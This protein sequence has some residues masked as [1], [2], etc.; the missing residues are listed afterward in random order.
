MSESGACYGKAEYWD[1]RYSKDAEPLE[2][3]QLTWAGLK[4][5]FTPYLK[6]EGAVINL[7]CGNS[8]LSEEMWDEGYRTITNID[9]SGV[10]IGQMKE[11]YAANQGLSFLHLDGRKL[12][13][14]SDNA[15]QMAIDK[16]T[17]DSLVCGE[18][19]AANAHKY[20]SEISRVL[21]RDGV[22]L[23][24]SHAQP[25]YRLNYLAKP[26]FQWQVETKTVP[27]PVV[28]TQVVA[29]D[30]KDNVYYIYICKKQC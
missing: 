25:A 13:G 18:A 20:L 21:T 30:E 14:I 2:W 9:V 22:L 11:K 7:G 15:F 4:D 28:A 6:K 24:V 16:A 1:A 12:D 17:L 8:R 10:V 3:H 23:L 27:R 29:P 5:V 19:A 26:E